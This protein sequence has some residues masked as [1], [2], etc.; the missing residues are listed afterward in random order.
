MQSYDERDNNLKY[1]KKELQVSKF[2]VCKILKTLS[3]SCCLLYVFIG[4]KVVQ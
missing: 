1:T 4:S 2:P 3:V